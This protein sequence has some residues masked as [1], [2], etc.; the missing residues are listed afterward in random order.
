MIR[1]R[2]LGLSAPN[3]FTRFGTIPTPI[4]RTNAAL[5]QTARTEATWNKPKDHRILPDPRLYV[6]IRDHQHFNCWVGVSGMLV[7]LAF[8]THMT[9]RLMQFNEN[10]VLNR[11]LQRMANFHEHGKYLEDS[12]LPSH[13]T[14]SKDRYGEDERLTVH[15][16]KKRHGFGKPDN[17]DGDGGSGGGKAAAAAAG[18]AASS[19]GEGQA[20]AEDEEEVPDLSDND[21]EEAKVEDPKNEKLEDPEKNG[22][23]ENEKPVEE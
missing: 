21:E 7:I 15:G 23:V 13:L 17:E 5:R 20:V 2:R 3:L 10:S 14:K 18:V 9:R 1:L 6:A 4:P 12:H 19:G 11:N 22:T 8:A 16:I